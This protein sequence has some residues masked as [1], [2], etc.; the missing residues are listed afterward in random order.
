MTTADFQ[1]VRDSPWIVGKC[2][3][4]NPSSIWIKR[5]LMDFCGRAAHQEVSLVG[6]LSEA[7]NSLA[8]TMVD[9]D[10]Q[11]GVTIGHSVC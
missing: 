3:K 2:Y 5:A 4:R 10:S 8:L 11:T 7:Q 1:F 9:W 6:H